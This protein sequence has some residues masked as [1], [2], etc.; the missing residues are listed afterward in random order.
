MPQGYSFSLGQP[1]QQRQQ[2]GYGSSDF[3]SPLPPGAVY[4]RS[5]WSGNDADMFVPR[6][7]PVY[8]PTDGI[9]DSNGILRGRT[10]GPSAS[11]TARPP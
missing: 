7:T 4:G 9:M 1:Q 5:K 3:A 10:A 6:G 2:Q 11:S 8:A